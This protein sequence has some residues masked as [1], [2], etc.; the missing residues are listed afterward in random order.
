MLYSYLRARSL[1]PK[2]LIVLA[3][4]ASLFVCGALIYQYER[5]HRPS[6]KLFFGEWQGMDGDES[7]KVYWRFRPDHTFAYFV[8]SPHSGEKLPVWEG[9]WYAGGPFLYLRFPG[10]QESRDRVVL[11]F[12]VSAQ[13]LTIALPH[14][15][16]VMWDLVRV[17][18]THEASNQAM[19]RTASKRSA[20][21]LSVCHPPCLCARSH[22]GL[23]VAD[24][25]SR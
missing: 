12:D 10:G 18:A 11:R 9:R 13:H 24:L 23:A 2:T 25:V 5:Y 17:S 8:I 16:G 20:Y 21:L 19:Q 1:A 14:S 6:D 15:R 22:S 4:I 7:E 3:M